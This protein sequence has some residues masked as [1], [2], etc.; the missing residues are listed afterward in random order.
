[1]VVICK[2]QG[3]P[4]RSTNGFCRNRVLSMNQDG[5]CSHLYKLAFGHLNA[6][7]REPVS[8][9]FLDGYILKQEKKKQGLLEENQ[10]PPQGGQNDSQ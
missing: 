2:V 10:Q 8:A 7:W 9:E 3:C 1:M 4:Y 6:K 5:S